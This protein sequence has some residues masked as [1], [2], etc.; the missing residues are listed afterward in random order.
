MVGSVIWV[1]DCNLVVVGLSAFSV[2]GDGSIVVCVIWLGG[3]V[4][5][6]RGRKRLPYQRWP[7]SNYPYPS[8]W[9]KRRAVVLARDNG[10]CQLGLP[11]C[12]SVAKQVDHIV[13]LSRGGNHDLSNL[14]ASCVHCNQG[15]RFLSP[16]PSRVW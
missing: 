13:P 4:S 2:W 8:D 15:R 14:R 7:R 11:G 1:K 5:V 9:S 3:G 10:V 12:T 6:S 16:K